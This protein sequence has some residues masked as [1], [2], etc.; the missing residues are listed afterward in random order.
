M[1]KINIQG[2]CV[3]WNSNVLIYFVCRITQGSGVMPDGTPC[4]TCKDQKVYHFMG[5]STFSEYTV[6][7]DIS[8]CKVSFYT[9]RV[10]L[11][12]NTYKY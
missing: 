10:T 4:F 9:Q 12:L 11:N 2:L 7:A 1:N 5:T 6:V 3:A 8:L